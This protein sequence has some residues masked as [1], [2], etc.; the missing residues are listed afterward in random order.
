M[1]NLFSIFDPSLYIMKSS[2]LSML[3]LSFVIIPLSIWFS[4][5]NVMFFYKIMNLISNEINYSMK[6]PKKGMTKIISMIFLMIS[7]LNFNALFP[8]LF[9]LTS[10]LMFT[11][12]V[13]Y[14]MWLGIIFMTLTK[15]IVDFLAH[16]IPMGTPIMLI[17]FMSLVEIISNI[18]RPL[19][20]M[21]RLTAN[22]MAG[23]LLL[24]LIGNTILSINLYMMSLGLFLLSPLIVM[25]MGVSLIQAYVF[26][27]LLTLY[28]SEM[29]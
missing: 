12:P 27:T 8:F 20:L 3:F 7:L 29:E 26:F 13:S 5:F 9:S 24:S 28:T 14:S 22:M 25:E 4:N 18:I 19:A 10:H 17:S 6:Q 11:L 16:L 1:T 23:H 2:Y 15:S 21:F